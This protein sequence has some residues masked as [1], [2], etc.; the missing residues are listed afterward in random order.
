MP[1]NPQNTISQA[2]LKHYNELRNIITE[3]LRWV[4]M[5]TYTGITFKVETSAKERDQQLL[6]FITIDILKL[7]QQHN[8]SEDI[9]NISMN[10]IINNS[11]NKHPMSWELIHCCLLNPSDSVMKAMCHHQTLDGL[12]KNFPKQIHKAPCTICYTSKMTTINKGTTVNTINLQPGELM[13]M[14]FAFYNVT[15]I[16]GFTSMLTVV[17]AKTKMLWVSPTA[18]KRAPVRI[19]RFILKTL[20]NEQHP[21]KIIRVDEDI[22]LE[23]ST[24]VTNLLVDDFKICTET[25][26]GDASWINVNN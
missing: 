12:P 26:G 14:E 9:S 7:E 6:D 19:I 2:A 21:C 25:T 23:N 3:A 22:S 5:N 16:R 8:S 17:C 1:Q 20:M 24:D 18:P 11:F 15:S 10:P 13:H 4:K